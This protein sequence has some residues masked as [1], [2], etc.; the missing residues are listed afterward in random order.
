M[1]L[2]IPY[3]W[4]P[5]P[6]QLSVILN[7]ARFKV[8]VW[9]RKA[10]KTTL[11]INELVRWAAAIKGTYW[12]V[13]PFLSQA[14]KIV[15]QDPG[16]LPNYVPPEIWAKRNNSD[17]YIPFPNGSI[18]YILGADRP[19]SLRGPNPMGVC[20]DEYGDMK[21]EIWS[22]IVQPIM[23]ANPDA[24]T[25]FLGTPKGRND[26]YVKFSYA[27]ENANWFSSILR[28]SE[29]GIIAPE[30][31]N[32]A[33]KTSTE[34][35][36]RQEYECDFLDNA[37]SFFRRIKENAYDIQDIPLTIFPDHKFNLGVDLAKYNDWSVITPFDLHTFIAH[38]PDRFNQVDYPMQKARIEAAHF[39]YN[40]ARLRIDGSHGSVGD[41]IVDDL[42][43]AGITI[44]DDDAVQFTGGEYGTR[45]K[46]LDGLAIK[47]EQDKI[48][49][50]NVE[51]L[52]QELESMSYQLSDKGRI[53]VKVPEGMHD[54]GIMSLALAVSGIDSPLKVNNALRQQINRNR[55]ENRSFK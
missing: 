17:L 30:W 10:R 44:L 54:D 42:R 2:H 19:D 36:F 13:A 52:I 45:R 24:W 37:N 4:Q 6:H 22:G 21:P 20:L 47:L 43:H 29:S 9:H 7:G 5:E 40:R 48:K 31:L 35:F 51:W 27:Q 11:A 28:A 41:P 49:I 55:Q 33:R 53:T 15:W 23:I 8:I 18:L 1:D 46:L 3:N 26:F 12:Y 16:M 14:K 25:W 34:S 50:P 39:R 38:I 32:E